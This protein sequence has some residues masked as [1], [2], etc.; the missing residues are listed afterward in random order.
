MPPKR[1]RRQVQAQKDTNEVEESHPG[2]DPPI[3]KRR[4]RKEESNS[5]EVVM[6]TTNGQ[7]I[8]TEEEEKSP[9]KIVRTSKRKQN[10]KVTW[11][12]VTDQ[13]RVKGKHI[14]K[15]EILKETRKKRQKPKPEERQKPKSEEKQK[16]K[17]E[18]RTISHPPPQKQKTTRKRGKTVQGPEKTLQSFIVTPDEIISHHSHSTSCGSVFMLGQGDIGQLGLGENMV[19]RKKP[20]PVGGA[21][22]GL[23]IIQVACGGMHTIALT[24]EGKVYTWGCNDE[25][26][27]GRTTSEGE[28]YSPGLV[29]LIERV[30]VVQVS[31]G[32]SHSVALANNGN[33]YCWGIFR[34]S[35]GPF[36][37]I[38][39]SP[40]Y[41]PQ[42]V[43]SSP[44]NKAIKT[45]SGCDHVVILTEQGD[46]YTF[47]C[48]E[49][50]QLG[51]IPECFSS[52]GGRK[53][54]GILLAPQVVRLRKIRG[55]TQPQFDDVFAGSYHTF[56]IAKSNNGVYSWGLNNYGQLGTGDT[57][58]RYQPEKL[59]DDWLWT[60]HQNKGTH[61]M[62]AGGQHHSIL[63]DKGKV[64]VTGRKEYGRL[65][66]GK[67][68]EEPISPREV[69]NLSDIVSV[70]C[71]S[72]CSF[73]VTSSGDAYSWGMGTNLQLGLDDDEDVW[74]PQKMTGKHLEGKKVISVSS[75][76]Q[77]T[78]LLISK[79]TVE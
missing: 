27:L 52:R 35:N 38:D 34:D 58:T 29:S 62:I 39:S 76:G 56:A 43:Y 79:E 21:L 15:D 19:E 73:G 16:P 49:Q 5:N 17:P 26:S 69:P 45:A 32:D 36:G 10:L 47:G 22:S 6:E 40:S 20:Y 48:G 77:H 51:R 71:G 28:E 72:C 60:W 4:K 11:E 33:V 65:G 70:A 18:K 7:S 42:L 1:P 30:N 50:G 61:L 68:E 2:D 8:V 66:L 25:G 59:P 46:I 74:K 75:G 55:H 3:T 78:A 63:C 54:V 37:M 23:N 67:N 13:G 53:G 41:T 24:D 14:K 31:A 44:F 12:G 64:Y 57:R 9:T